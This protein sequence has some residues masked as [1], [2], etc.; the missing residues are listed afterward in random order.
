MMSGDTPIKDFPSN[1]HPNKDDFFL[2]WM[3]IMV[4]LILN[5]T[6]SKSL[7]KNESDKKYFELENSK[8]YN[9]VS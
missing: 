9:N 8:Q 3:I 5:E 2:V 4:I 7:K 1:F 6:W